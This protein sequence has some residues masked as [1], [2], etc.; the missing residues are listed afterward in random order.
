ARA[1]P[2]ADASFDAVCAMD[3]L[4]HVDDLPAI[5]GEAARV[6]APDGLFFFHTFNR[7]PLSFFVVIKGVE[8]FVRNVPHDMHLFRNFIKPAE[9]RSVGEDRGLEMREVVGCAPRLS[10]AFMRLLVTGIVAPTFA[11]RFTRRP[12][13]GYSGVARRVSPPAL[14]P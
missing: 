11:F 7:N 8:W 1:L 10:L 13:T 9:L 4:E 14:P 12:V 5:L 6:L 2:L 3:F